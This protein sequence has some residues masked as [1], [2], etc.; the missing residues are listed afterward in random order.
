MSANP[1]TWWPPT[2]KIRWAFAAFLTAEAGLVA[3]QIDG[4]NHLGWP[5]V[6]A[7]GV[8]GLVSLVTG[9]LTSDETSS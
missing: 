9:Y 7:A 1:T 8:V 6:I 4:A 5:A 3:G 2:R